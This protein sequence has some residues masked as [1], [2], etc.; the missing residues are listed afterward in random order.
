M[1]KPSA[2]HPYSWFGTSHPALAGLG[3]VALINKHPPWNM[4][5]GPST[6]LHAA[7]VCNGGI[8]PQW[9]QATGGWMST[10]PAHDEDARLPGCIT[11]VAGCM[12]DAVCPTHSHKKWAAQGVAEAEEQGAV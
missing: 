4:Q 12:K 1:L 8:T 10:I 2:P 7:G 3:Q 6:G 5:V 9:N 11:P